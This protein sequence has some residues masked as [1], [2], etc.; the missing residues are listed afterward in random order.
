MNP[1]A[2]PSA[3]ALWPTLA[4]TWVAF[5]HVVSFQGLTIWVIGGS[6]LTA[7]VVL[8]LA[9]AQQRL[10]A[11]AAMI[12]MTI[13]VPALAESLG[14]ES[15]GPIT[16]ASIMS[17]GVT[18]AMAIIVAGRYAKFIVPVSL[19]LLCGA[20]GLGA[21]GQV[22]WLAGIWVIAA[23]LTL[24]MLGPYRQE[25]LRE[26][27]RLVSFAAMLTAIGF[28]ALVSLV[29]IAPFLTSPWTIPGSSIETQTPLA[30]VT[31]TSVEPLPV[32]P[33]IE[34]SA[35]QV[36]Q[37]IAS[38]EPQVI[39][40]QIIQWILWLLL[41]LLLLILIFIVLALLRRAFIALR[42]MLL[43]H[44]LKRGTPAAQVI[45]AWTWVRLKRARYDQP[46]P[47]WVSPDVAVDWA[48]KEGDT[49]LARIAT[50][51]AYVAF[52]S[53]PQVTPSESAFAW[54]SALSAGK[55]PRGSLRRRWLWLARGPRVSKLD[56]ESATG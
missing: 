31:E 8:P 51:T 48:R 46:I 16:R 40:E 22:L 27:R 18:G 21:A 19:V 44:R 37:P 56:C 39:T 24:S 34:S 49:E 11:I 33:D 9:F 20:L 53:D 43:R 4:L 30:P 2:H 13:L 35:E 3:W 36:Q 29:V 17:A 41:L 10:L 23:A 25:H 7:L 14:G 28:L 54:K 42:W 15:A 52:S 38:G 45:G 12:G 5:A 50:I 32:T 55:A 26:R 6:L 1:R 47:V